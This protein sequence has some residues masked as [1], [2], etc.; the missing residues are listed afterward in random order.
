MA[1]TAQ[2]QEKVLKTIESTQLLTGGQLNPSQQREFFKLIRT[3]PGMFSYARFETVDQKKH[4]IDKLHIGEPI[5]HSVDENSNEAYLAKPKTSQLEIYTKK[6]KSSWNVTTETLVE[7]IEKGNFEQTLME[8]M[9]QR[10]GTDMELLAIQGDMTKY[11]S[12]T[13]PKGLLLRRDDGWDKITDNAHIVDCGGSTIIKDIFAEMIRRM[14]QQYLAD[15]EL[16]WITSKTIEVDWTDTVAERATAMGDAAYSGKAPAPYGIPMLSIPL[17]PA[18]KPLS[19]TAATSAQVLGT[20]QD[21]FEI[22]EGVNDKL[23]IDID[24]A[25]A[26]TGTEI[27]LAAGVWHAGQI[28]NM[29]N[30]AL[31]NAPIASTDGFGRIKLQSL[32]TGTASEID[33][34]AIANDAYK[35]LGFTVGVI[36]GTDD[37][38]AGTVNEGSFIWLANPKNF[39]YVLLNGTR[40]YSEFNKDYDRLETVVYNEMDVVV[41]NLDAVVKAV[42]VRRR[43]L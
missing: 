31:G 32:T 7:N 27:T 33:I 22:K 36:N 26:G 24:N 1:V 42:N 40:V 10:I 35:T 25:G 41:E 19:L 2:Q 43:P 39:I 3:L 5:T 34:Q 29:I 38:T 9:S 11:A 21:V 30:A 37:G 23:K 8:G 4:H 28:A 13:T 18:D 20:R 17:I 15:P 12:D 6:L 14:P 16:R